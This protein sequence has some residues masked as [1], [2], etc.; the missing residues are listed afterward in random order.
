MRQFVGLVCAL[1]VDVTDA[2]L[3]REEPFVFKRD[4]AYVVGDS[5]GHSWQAAG[6]RWESLMTFLYP[7]T[8][9]APECYDGIDNDGDGAI[10]FVPNAPTNDPD[11]TNPFDPSEGE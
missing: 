8:D 2:L 1:A 4:L 11:C 6:A 3:L 9:D 7:V 10:D 5:L